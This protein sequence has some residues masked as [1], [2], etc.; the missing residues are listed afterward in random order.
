MEGRAFFSLRPPLM[1]SSMACD[2][3]AKYGING[4]DENRITAE[5][6]KK[7]NVDRMNGLDLE[8]ARQIHNNLLAA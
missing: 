1:V 7:G 3:T 8:D 4:T 6:V 5:G 2:L